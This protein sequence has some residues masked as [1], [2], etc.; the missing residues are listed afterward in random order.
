MT[1]L[2]KVTSKRVH[3]LVSFLFCRVLLAEP[4]YQTI[5]EFFPSPSVGSFPAGALA[6]DV[7]GNFYGVTTDGV[8]S[9]GTIFRLSPAGEFTQLFAFNGTN[10]NS[11]FG[12]LVWG[13]DKNLYGAT[14]SLW[15]PTNQGT[16]FRVTTSGELTTLFTFGGTNGS[17]PHGPLAKGDQGD[18]YGTTTSGGS[19]NRGTVFRISTNGVLT[20]LFSFDGTN[21]FS[22]LAALTRAAD[23]NFYG[24][25]E[26][27]GIG[28]TGSSL[29]RGTLFRITTNG[30][31][32]TIV[33]FDGTNGMRPSP[34]GLALGSDQCLYGTTYQS[35][36][37]FGTV[38]KLDLQGTL[39]TLAHFY[40][41]NGAF[42]LSGIKQA[43]DGNFYGATANRLEGNNFTNGTLF[44]ISTNGVIKTL[45]LFDGTNSLNPFVNFTLSFDGMLYGT[46]SDVGKNLSL[47]G[48]AG[49][50]FR[51]LEEPRILSLSFSNDAALLSWTSFTNQS[52]QVQF[53]S[54]LDDPDWLL[55]G[56][57]IVAVDY[58]SSFSDSP[59]A[60]SRYYR[61]VHV[62]Y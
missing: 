53:K 31:L 24:T 45:V 36:N 8:A 5:Y 40:G 19:F 10:G 2:R 18:F 3:F 60:E 25:T 17:S 13:D 27:G 7:D 22:P 26:F 59:I 39:T 21:G 28:Y 55:V 6:Q 37:S 44:Q 34:G 50:V 62:P 23:G 9:F 46:I 54:T 30:I 42:P 14:R 47:K 4:I 58:I 20:T 56:S 41:T 12:G 51:L 43:L 48:N 15:P 35:T 11:P 1:K 29:G 16:I 57:T 33:Y 49:T 61:I 38:F 52:Y 32:N